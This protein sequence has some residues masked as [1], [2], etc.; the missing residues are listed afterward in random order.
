MID[1]YRY[2]PDD[3]VGNPP[4]H[5]HQFGEWCKVSD[6]LYLLTQYNAN[7]ADMNRLIEYV[8]QHIEKQ[9]FSLKME[10]TPF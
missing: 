8:K 10:N 7:A 5:K 2:D 1:R 6:I 4:L 3:D 9:V